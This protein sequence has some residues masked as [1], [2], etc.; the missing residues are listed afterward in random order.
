MRDDKGVVAVFRNDIIKNHGKSV[1]A[2]RPIFDDVEVVELRY[3]GSKNVGVFPAMEFSH[4]D[5]DEMNGGQRA[6]TYAE[7][8]PRQYQQF[9]AHQQQTKAGTP[10]DYL[11]FLTEA[12]RAEL[13]ALNIYTAEALTV[14]DGPELKN[15]GPG[16]REMK[17]QA[18]AFLESSNDASR[19]TKLEAELLEMRARNQ[20]LEDDIKSGMLDKMPPSSFDGMT[21]EQ[22][23]AHIKSMTGVEPKGNLPRKTLIR[24]AQEQKENV[25]A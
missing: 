11:P 25:A 17:N 15:L 5:E 9:K 14:V 19:V 13:R 2:G 22:L 1:E 10:L 20:V 3:A 12:R 16:G 21:D 6:Y 8:F 23:R 24:M 18:I 4:W 7:R